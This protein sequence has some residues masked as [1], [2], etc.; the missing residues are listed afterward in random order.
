M[1]QI[2]DK[3]PD[4]KLMGVWGKMRNN[5]EFADKYA[6]AIVF[7]CNSNKYSQAY[8]QRLIKLFDKYEED[9]F[10]I[11]GINSND[12][13][14]SPED[15][16]EMMVKASYHYK[17][18]ERNFLYLHDETQETA[19]AF[20]A[21]YNPEVFLFNS[22]RELVYKGAIDDNWENDQLV[23]QAYLEDAIEYSLDGIEV[24]FPEI[25][26]TEGEPIIW[27]PGNE[28]DYVKVKS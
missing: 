21:K 23:T 10:A 18:H 26:V 7:T 12:A 6:L 14:Q 4:F 5:F 20:G 27:K 22:K 15:S 8:S 25:P 28:P 19:K 13:I 3:M 17:L 16:F 2:G 11:I 1:L 24:D 9:N